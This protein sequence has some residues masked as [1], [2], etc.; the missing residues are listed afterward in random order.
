MDQTEYQ[1]EVG[2]EKKLHKTHFQIKEK[3]ELEGES[4]AVWVEYAPGRF[5]M[6]MKDEL[7]T[8]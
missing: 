4:K 6:V 5:K 3:K 8:K 1:G 2:H 7:H